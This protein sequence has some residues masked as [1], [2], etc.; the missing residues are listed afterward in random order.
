MGHLRLEFRPKPFRVQCFWRS[1]FALHTHTRSGPPHA[2]HLNLPLQV[3]SVTPQGSSRLVTR[4]C[5]MYSRLQIRPRGESAKVDVKCPIRI[6]ILLTR[7]FLEK[8]G[9]NKRVGS[10]V[11]SS[12]SAHS[13]FQMD[14]ERDAENSVAVV[15]LQ[16]CFWHELKPSLVPCASR[17]CFATNASPFHPSLK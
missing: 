2:D 9:F 17:S 6:P 14:N 1:G 11:G 13:R 8:S 4:T 7:N 15:E 5:R 16:T 3:L 12:I 10:F